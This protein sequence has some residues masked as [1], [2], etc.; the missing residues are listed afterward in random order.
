MKK[1]FLP[2][3]NTLLYLS[4]FSVLSFSI[5][6]QN[7][8]INATGATPNSSAML[9]LNTG[10]TFTSPNGK[11]LMIPNVS[12][13]TT[14]D[15]T[16]VPVAA[17]QNSILVYNTN[18]AITGTG[19]AGT[20]YYYWNNSAARWVNLIDNMAP[21]S[22][23][24]LLGNTSI[25]TPAVP[26]TYGTST[27]GV[28]ENFLGTTDAND[29]VFGTNNIERM[30]IMQTTGFVGI[31]TAAPASRLHVRNLSANGAAV[32]GSMTN[33]TGYLGYTNN[34]ALGAFGTV[35][36][37]SVFSADPTSNGY[38]SLV[39]M[40]TGTANYAATISYSDIWIG[41][42]FGVDNA[43]AGFSP[44]AIYG[45]VNHTVAA[46]GVVL[47]PAV[48]GY[49]NNTS[50]GNPAYSNGMLAVAIGN[51]QDCFGVWGYAQ[52]SSGT[53]AGGYFEAYNNTPTLQAYA[54]VGSSVGGT[55][56][57]ILG[58]N[59]VSEIVPTKNHGR[60]ILTCPESPE[61][62]YQDYGTVKLVNGKAHVDLESTILEICVIDQNNP[63]KVFTT[64]DDENCKGLAIKKGL[65]G[66]DIVEMGGGISNC[67]VDYQII[68]RPK[69]GY[70]EGRFP[71]APGPAWLKP[72]FEPQSAKAKNQTLGRDIF[73]WPADWTVYGYDVEKV[74]PIGMV[75][76][77]GPHAGKIKIADGVFADKMPTS[78]PQP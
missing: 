30:R 70:G 10:N 19:S 8:G 52:T 76:P 39:V 17:A 23:W 27:F 32:Q 38:P 51:A 40:S 77:A 21:G 43:Q 53:R 11:G 13:T 12:L 20:G 69:T 34:I 31:G 78:K 68:L 62:W 36:G 48:Q 66:F 22:P 61:Y 5:K 3:S 15:N 42:Y 24:M 59:S 46:S 73:Y 63:I 65:T 28:A 60:I 29:V 26:G 56:R 58:T 9:D 41:G 2:K 14:T 25:S 4:F 44:S 57:K 1:Y 72:E 47:R 71:Q 75:V 33:V 54:Y 64:V 45:Q 49:H 50:A 67:T 37:A 16:T 6:A 55:N 7:V 18:A 74:I 35:P